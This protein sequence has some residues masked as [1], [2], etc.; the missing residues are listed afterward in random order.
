[1]NPELRCILSVLPLET[2]VLRLPSAT[3]PINTLNAPSGVTN[4]AGAKA[5]AAKFA[6]SPITTAC[7][8]PSMISHGAVCLTYS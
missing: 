1:M 2:S 8:E 3:Y 4:I 7:C 6:I 5:Y